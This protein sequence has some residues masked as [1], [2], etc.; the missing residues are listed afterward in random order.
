M[1]RVGGIADAD[2]ASSKGQ[3]SETQHR[4]LRETAKSARKAQHHAHS[5]RAGADFEFGRSDEPRPT[6]VVK[7]ER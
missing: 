5:G 3:A 1:Q 6:T 2:A 4:G 7:Q